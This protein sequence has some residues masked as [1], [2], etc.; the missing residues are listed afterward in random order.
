MSP[1]LISL[2]SIYRRQ[3]VLLDFVL[4]EILGGSDLNEG[5]A[6]GR[7]LILYGALNIQRVSILSL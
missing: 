3:P 1:L 7:L 5:L 6:H 2:G 4:I